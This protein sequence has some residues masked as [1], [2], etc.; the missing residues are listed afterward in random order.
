MMF[1]P[2]QEEVGEQ[3]EVPIMKLLK[4]GFCF[5]L[6]VAASLPAVAQAFMQA[7]IPFNFVTAGKSFPAGIIGLNGYMT[8]ISRYGPFPTAMLGI[9]C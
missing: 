5:A 2:V 8:R 4:L 9:S 1:S 7:N 6:L 3:E